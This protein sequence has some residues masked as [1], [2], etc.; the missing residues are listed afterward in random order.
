MSEEGFT[1]A[2]REV[3]ERACRLYGSVLKGR[4]LDGDERSEEEFKVLRSVYRKC[5]W[6]VE[7]FW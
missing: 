4:V 2:E 7:L 6:T 1:K 3:L 5:R